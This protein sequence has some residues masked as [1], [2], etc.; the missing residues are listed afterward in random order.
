MII[1]FIVFYENDNSFPTMTLSLSHDPQLERKSRKLL[2][3]PSDIDRVASKMH[4]EQQAQ[5][6]ASLK[7]LLLL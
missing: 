7:S 4:Q 6:M 1:V 2:T 3:S 5:N